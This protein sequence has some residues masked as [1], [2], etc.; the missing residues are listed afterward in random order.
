MRDLANKKK[1]S[2]II[3]QIAGEKDRSS[4]ITEIYNNEPG[5][6]IKELEEYR[7]KNKNIPVVKEKKK[8]TRGEIESELSKHVVENWT[9]LDKA[10]W[11][12]ER[13]N[14]NL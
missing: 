2:A 1:I 14:S 3:D 9:K 5:L 11:K 12:K 6:T 4:I 7:A 10:K 8:K 13:K